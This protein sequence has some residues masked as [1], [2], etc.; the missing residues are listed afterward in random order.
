MILILLGQNP[1]KKNSFD[2]SL[3]IL[4]FWVTWF[5]YFTSICSWYRGIHQ[6]YCFSNN[7]VT[8]LFYL[9]LGQRMMYWWLNLFNKLTYFFQHSAGINSCSGYLSLQVQTSLDLILFASLSTWGF[10]KRNLSRYPS[11]DAWGIVWASTE[12]VHW[13]KPEPETGAQFTGD[14]NYPEASCRIQQ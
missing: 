10:S 6:I 4:Y 8:S 9:T 12:G 14:W 13:I 11:G 1:S 3:T 2:F 5:E 7:S